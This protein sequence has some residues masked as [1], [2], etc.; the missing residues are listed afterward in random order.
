MTSQHRAILRPIVLG[1]AL[2]LAAPP[3]WAIDWSAVPAKTVSL[4][5]PGQASWEW[6][7]SKDEHS[8]APKFREGKNCR[9][10]HEKETEQIGKA[11]AAGQRLEKKPIPGKRGTIPLTVRFAHDG[12]K[13]WVRLEFPESPA[14]GPKM[15]KDFVGRVTMMFDDGKVV[16]FTRAGCWSICHD[17]VNGMP[18]AVEGKDMHKYLARSRAKV[19][20][21]GGG[22]SQKPDDALATMF[23]DGQF[24]EYWQTRLKT[25]GTGIAVDGHALEKRT[26][27]ATPKVTSETKLEGGKWIVTMSRPLVVGAPGYKDIAAG[28][29][30]ALGF[31]VHEDWSTGRYHVVSLEYSMSLDSGDADFIAKKM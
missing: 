30:Y 11:L 24:I 14:G 9:E 10:C 27:H 13:L 5:Y 17:D 19:S 18:S 8:A 16:E 21:N 6:A 3:A 28:K 20:R 4:M 1:A 29:K 26:D 7:L 22:D 2:A 31:A 15:D 12:Q 25:G 23:A